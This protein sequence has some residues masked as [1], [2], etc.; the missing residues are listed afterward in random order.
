MSGVHLPRE[1]ITIEPEDDVS[2]LKRI[3]V[4]VAFMYIWS[5]T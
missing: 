3:G 1:V 2:D 4:E 5:I